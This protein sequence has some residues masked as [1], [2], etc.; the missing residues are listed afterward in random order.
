[1]V[2]IQGK[3]AL[4]HSGGDIR[5]VKPSTKVSFTLLLT[6]RNKNSLSA[7]AEQVATPGS[8]LFH[9]YLTLS[10][11]AKNFGA[12]EKTV[13]SVDQW[14]TQNHLKVMSL[15]KNRLSINVRGDAALIEKTFHTKLGDYKAGTDQGQ[16]INLNSVYVSKRLAPAIAGVIGLDNLTYLSPT[17]LDLSKNSSKAPKPKMITAANLQNI[18]DKKI[19]VAHPPA[20]S[21]HA[22]TYGEVKNNNHLSHL[23]RSPELSQGSSAGPVISS[24]CLQQISASNAGLSIDQ[25]AGAYGFDP[26]YLS[27][28]TAQDSTVALIEFAPVRVSDIQ[29]FAS[30]YGITTGNIK[31]IKVRGGPGKYTAS[32]ELEAELDAEM[33][34]GLAPG[35]N[36][37]IY[38]GPDGKGNVTNTAAYEVEQ[39][40]VNNPNVKVIST[41]WGGCEQSVG[42]EVASAE[43]YLFEQSALEG[44]TWVAAAGDVGSTDCYGQVKGP[45][46]KQLA[47]DDPA[48]Q[49]FVTGVGGTTLSISPTVS[50]TAWN[51]TLSGR[52]PGAGGGG[53][54]IFWAMPGYQFNTPKTLNVKSPYSLC[55][56]GNTIISP[57][58][59]KIPTL[60]GKE[61]CREVPDVS[62]NAGTPIATYCSIGAKSL[63]N[64]FCSSDN[65]TPIGGT[66]AAAPIWAAVFALADSSSACLS[67]GPVGFANPALYAIASGPDYSSSLTDVTTGNN[68]LQGTDPYH[69]S[70]GEGYSPVTGLGTPIVE[71]SAG[72]GGLIQSLCSFATTPAYQE[73]LPVPQVISITPDSARMRGGAKIVLKGINFT[74]ATAVYFGNT[75]A[76]SYRIVSSK[77]IIV[78]APPAKGKLHVTVRSAAGRSAYYPGNVFTFLTPPVIKKISLNPLPSKNK[79]RLIIYGNYF[80]AVK[81]VIF[82]QV[83]AK[84]QVTSPHTILVAIPAGTG[85]AAIRIKSKGGISKISARSIYRY[86]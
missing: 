43:N 64:N 65:W 76:T 20:R 41:S 51:T 6:P 79:Y 33:L 24:S 66:S 17:E 73:S 80:Y 35:V 19:A 47:V 21:A 37:D 61:I 42:E 49:P 7:A 32:G 77:K 3:A 14:L 67:G 38:E 60:D 34:V 81:Q 29:S 18:A 11:F 27:G 55:S 54:S 84:Y 22:T 68:N 52:E 57:I 72:N 23:S 31:Q 50:Q 82:G 13:R 8:K 70:A 12:G 59:H 71:N 2:R 5:Q 1:M 63:I 40:V 83:L 30:C 25:I 36:L 9:R 86:R 74:K 85:K 69:Y 16:L 46:A 75:K 62:A 10:E 53:T 4:T 78:I 15:S 44:Q 39:A 45:L 48:S 58:N 28:A 26:A 56:S